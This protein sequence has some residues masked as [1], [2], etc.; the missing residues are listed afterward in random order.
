[1]EYHIQVKQEINT[2]CELNKSDKNIS[3]T[4]V[5]SCSDDN[6]NYTYAKSCKGGNS[7]L[8]LF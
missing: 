1:M 2:T 7:L 6:L 5:I 3:L 8:Y 4:S